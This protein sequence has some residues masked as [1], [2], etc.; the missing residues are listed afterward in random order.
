MIK[1]S[2]I[3]A[4]FKSLCQLFIFMMDVMSG[5]VKIIGMDIYT[6]ELQR[7]AHVIQRLKFFSLL[8]KKVIVKGQ[9]N[10]IKQGPNLIV[11]NHIGSFKDIAVL[12][13]IVP[14]PM[15]FTANKNIFNKDEFSALIRR[16]LRI[17]FKDVGL[18]TDLVF[19]PLKQYFVNYISTNIAKIG[20]IPVDLDGKK[21]LAIEKCQDYVKAGRAVVLLQGRGRIVKNSSH[22]YI[23]LSP[24]RKGPAI[25]SY[26]LLK[27][28]N[29]SVPVTP[30]AMLGTHAPFLI[31]GKIRVNVGNPMRIEN[32][33]GSDFMTSVEIFRKALE[34]QVM[35]LLRDLIPG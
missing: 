3:P 6:Q 8:G 19:K 21:R 9:N 26:N 4:I 28:H 32:H 5:Y 20:S 10:F 24:F 11:G 35:L 18:L 33:L 30:V 27:Q 15:Y 16:H 7:L 34:N 2:W 12:F 25:I 1:V 31:P 29:I 14:R 13:H 22:P 17:H 23:Y